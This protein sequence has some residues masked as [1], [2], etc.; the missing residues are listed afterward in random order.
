MSKAH[1][2]IHFS[3]TCTEPRIVI[4]PRDHLG[5]FRSPVRRFSLAVT[6]SHVTM[7]GEVV[8]LPK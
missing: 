2:A 5:K 7:H 3:G 8:R 1:M 6:T 4:Q